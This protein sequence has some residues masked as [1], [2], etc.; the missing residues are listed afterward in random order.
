M[1]QN[2]T[3][4]QVYN[5]GVTPKN[6]IKLGKLVRTDYEGMV[7][8]LRLFDK[9]TLE[10]AIDE[11]VD[12]IVKDFTIEKMTDILCNL[13]HKSKGHYFSGMERIPTEDEGIYKW[14]VEN[15]QEIELIDA[16]WKAIIL[17]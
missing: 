1:K 2:I 11:V 10:A 3:K 9:L 13:W 4:Q 8:E 5:F 7:N 12:Q 14:D 6:M 16:L 15:F 17:L